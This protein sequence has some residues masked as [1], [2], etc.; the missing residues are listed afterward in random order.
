MPVTVSI[1]RKFHLIPLRLLQELLIKP[2]IWCN[3]VAEQLPFCVKFPTRIVSIHHFPSFTV[4]I[5]HFPFQTFKVHSSSL[6]KFIFCWWHN[7]CIHREGNVVCNDTWSQLTG[8]F[9]SCHVP[10]QVPQSHVIWSTI[11]NQLKTSSKG[12]T[13]TLCKK[14]NWCPFLYLWKYDMICVEVMRIAT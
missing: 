5:A 10:G 7:K 3:I 9:S 2:A 1:K 13:F 8:T 11:T 6:R 14:N 12:T 4:S